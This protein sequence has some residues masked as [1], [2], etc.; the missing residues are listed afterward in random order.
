MNGVAWSPNG[1]W[2]ATTSDDKSINLWDADKRIRVSRSLF[3]HSEA[4]VSV[5]WSPDNRMIYSASEGGE[6]L[7]WDVDSETQVHM[8]FG[9]TDK[10]SQIV[11]LDDLILVSASADGT[12]RIWAIPSN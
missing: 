9:H 1:K 4:S 5:V 7:V 12:V 2:I 8:L 3:G 6:I 10:I 11:L